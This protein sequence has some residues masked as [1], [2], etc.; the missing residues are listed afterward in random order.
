MK[1]V[2]VPQVPRS[3]CVEVGVN[4]S[5]RSLIGPIVALVFWTGAPAQAAEPVLTG[6]TTVRTGPH[7]ASAATVT[8][9][10][11]TRIERVNFGETLHSLLFVAARQTP[12]GPRV[13]YMAAVRPPE[14][15]FPGEPV[16]ARAETDDVG[17]TDELPVGTIPAGEYVFYVVAPQGSPGAITL[18]TDGGE[19]ASTVT[20][21]LEASGRSRLLADGPVLRSTPPATF[22]YTA[23]GNETITTPRGFVF[24]G[25]WTFSPAHVDTQPATCIYNG[26]AP[27]TGPT[28]TGCSGIG[29]T[30]VSTTRHRVRSTAWREVVG[31]T[32][33]LGYFSAQVVPADRTGA[34]GAWISLG[35]ES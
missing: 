17:G 13:E 8:V 33:G 16:E 21:T 1:G 5:V 23:S 24:V 10:R 6:S 11:D 19:L 15:A 9:A 20:P 35:S 30:N 31:G 4:R 29:V 32:S 18:L 3:L 34:Y 14:S 28:L 26:P 12:S 27:A 7:E 2:A 25:G 22:V